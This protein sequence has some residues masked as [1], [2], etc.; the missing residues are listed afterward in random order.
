MTATALKDRAVEFLMQI[1]AG[2]VRGAYERHVGAGL[3]H[4]NPYF[5]G[6]L[7]SLRSGMEADEASHPGKR[8]E[9]R[10]ALQDGDQVA[11]HSRIRRGAG[12]PD[13]AVVHLFRFEEG[14]IVELWDV[15]QAVPAD[16]IN[17][18]GMF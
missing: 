13:F 18:H 14:R 11:V 15:V 17:E 4:H 3:R 10:C 8:L 6:D 7:E 12:E 1:V 16:C 2:D 5:P 9:V